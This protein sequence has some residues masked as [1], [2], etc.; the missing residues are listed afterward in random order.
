MGSPLVTRSVRYSEWDPSW[1][2]GYRTSARRKSE[3][4]ILQLAEDDLVLS[5]FPLPKFATSSIRT[6]PIG[7]VHPFSR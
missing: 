5:S 4:W 2:E 1:D 7:K 6:R 3:G